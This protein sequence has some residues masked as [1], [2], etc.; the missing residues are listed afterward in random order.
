[1][2][3]PLAMLLDLFLGEEIVYHVLNFSVIV[4][5]FADR[6]LINIQEDVT[7]QS[8]GDMTILTF[9]LSIG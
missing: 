3:A 9:K 7:V 1:M 2:L 6:R 8:L 5:F 4:S